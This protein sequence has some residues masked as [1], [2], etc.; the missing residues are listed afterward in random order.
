MIYDIVSF[1]YEYVRKAKIQSRPSGNPHGRKKIKY[2]DV[3]AAFDIETTRLSDLIPEQSVMYV[4]QF[5]IDDYT[6]MGRTWE[7]F[8]QFLALLKEQ[9]RPGVYM[10][11]WVHNLSY[12]FAFLKGIYA[13]S[14]DEVFC[15]DPHKVL[16]C[17]MAEAFEFRCS[18]YQTN[19]S[20]AQFTKKMGVPDA[21]LSGFDYDKIRYPWTPLT[22]D[23]IAYCVHDVKG[24]VQA[25]R[26]QMQ[27]DRDNLYTVP[28]TS[29]GYVR[30]DARIA[31]EGYN[32]RQLKALLPPPEVYRMLRDGFRGGDTHANRW[33]VGDILEGPGSKDRSSSYPAC[34][35]NHLYPMGEWFIERDI[36]ARNISRLLRKYHKA[37]ITELC[38]YDITEINPYMGRPYLSDAKCRNVLNAKIDNGRILSADYLE[39][40][41]TDVDLRILLECYHFKMRPKKIASCRYGPLPE[42]LLDVIREY[43]RAKTALKGDASQQIYYEKSKAKLNSIYGMMAQDPVKDTIHFVNNEFVP[44]DKPVEELL[45]KSYRKAFLSYAWGV[46]CTS[47]ARWELHQAIMTAARSEDCDFIYCDTDSIKYIGDLDLSEYNA[48]KIREST[49]HRAYA[50]DINGIQH[51][52]GVFEDEGRYKRFCTLGAKKYVYEDLDGKLHITIAGVSKKAGAEEL[53][54]IENF[55]EG[56]TFVKAGGTEA[57]YNDSV[58]LWIRREGHD[59]HI[60]DNV[61]IRPDVYTLG[62]A[63]DYQRILDGV[64]EIKYSAFEMPGLYRFKK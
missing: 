38:L 34:C 16:K 42:Q 59:L 32:H 45:E 4:W 50:D 17:E 29:T 14:P 41:V 39:T 30:R 54:R 23:E 35:F 28:L 47:W 62:I 48:N 20:L 21:K 6:I 8:T 51:Y 24:L 37:F 56:F 46:W 2:L 60:T 61:V 7:E 11:I 52:M 3:M 53:G 44:E 33:Y 12:E 57:V 64:M 10:V 63:G 22:D 27:M 1:P 18:Y 5:Q 25:M 31:M 49:A 43:Y 26:I 19:M 9:L 58:D 40:T 36:S 15:T 55:K 13:F